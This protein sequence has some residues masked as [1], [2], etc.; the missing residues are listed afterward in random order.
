MLRYDFIKFEMIQLNSK[1][2]NM[3]RYDILYF[4]HMDIFLGL[5]AAALDKFNSKHN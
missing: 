2:H 1:Q 3:I 4:P 5:S